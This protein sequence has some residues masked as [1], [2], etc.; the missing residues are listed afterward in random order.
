VAVSVPLAAFMLGVMCIASG[1][2]RFRTGPLLGMR[3]PMI[4]A[5]GCISVGM[6]LVLVCVPRQ[7]PSL[8]VIDLGRSVALGTLE[9]TVLV[10]GL[11]VS[12]SRDDHGDNGERHDTH[13]RYSLLNSEP[14]WTDGRFHGRKTA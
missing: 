6:M 11:R 12:W 7:V 2:L 1:A 3:R 8:M 10:V 4:V 9:P 5:H 13:W 14:G